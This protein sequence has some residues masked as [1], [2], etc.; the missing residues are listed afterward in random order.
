MAA[1]GWERRHAHARHPPAGVDPASGRD[2]PVNIVSVS[3]ARDNE[4]TAGKTVCNNRGGRLDIR[5]LA[6]S[7]QFMTP[8]VERVEDNDEVIFVEKCPARSRTRLL[9]R[10]T[11]WPPGWI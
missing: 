1:R 6:E 2:P 9:V 7:D 4:T 10:R 8:A 5:H 11:D 3:R